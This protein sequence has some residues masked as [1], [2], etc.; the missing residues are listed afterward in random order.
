M[1]KVFVT[2]LT[3]ILCQAGIAQNE[4]MNERIDKRVQQLDELLD[5]STEQ[6]GAIQAILLE[7]ATQA[8]EIRAQEDFN[9][10]DIKA[11]RKS[12]SERIKVELTDAQLA[13]LEAHKAAKKE[14]TKAKRQE[15]KEHRKS[16]VKPALKEE[17]ARFETFLSQEEKDVIAN[18]RLMARA[19]HQE[20]KESMD[21]EERRSKRME[22][23]EMLEPIMDAHS[24]ELSEVQNRLKPVLD[25]HKALKQESRV[26]KHRHDVAPPAKGHKGKFEVRFLLMEP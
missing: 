7:T 16:E 6:E 2:V 10:E 19:M 1:K 15:I 12:T 17:R 18:A 13:T 21:K 25:E 20:D 23:K 14:E 9:K 11:L 4:R 26:R 8:K 3:L 24:E 5:L 22:I